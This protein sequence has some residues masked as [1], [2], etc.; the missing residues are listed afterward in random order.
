[1]RLYVPGLGRF[2]QVDPVPGGGAN[3][4]DYARQDPLNTFDLDGRFGWKKFFK[5]VLRVAVAA[6]TV[7]SMFSCPVCTAIGYGLAAYSAYNGYRAYQRRDWGGVAWAAA[8]V[9]GVGLGRMASKAGRVTR[10]L[11][12]RASTVRSVRKAAMYAGK[13]A[14]WRSRYALYRT[15]SIAPSVIQLSRWE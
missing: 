12:G 6:A 4:Y 9:F 7:A 5:R 13:A 15:G 10:F 3:A 1:V 8:D 2:L 14:R 11:E